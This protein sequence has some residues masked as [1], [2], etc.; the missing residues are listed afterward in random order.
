L[1]INRLEPGPSG[2]LG[3][4]ALTTEV[5]GPGVFRCWFRGGMATLRSVS[6]DTGIMT[7]HA[8]SDV[9]KEFSS[10]VPEGRFRFILTGSYQSWID[11]VS[12]TPLAPIGLSAAL[13]D[14]TGIPLSQ[15]TG[16][17]PGAGAWADFSFDGEDSVLL[18]PGLP[19]AL[20][21]R[22]PAGATIALRARSMG[23]DAILVVGAAE[24][25]FD[26]RASLWTEVRFTVAG[27]SDTDGVVIRGSSLGASILLD[28][29]RIDAPPPTPYEKWAETT[30]LLGHPLGAP[31]QDADNDGM[32][33]LV[34]FAFGLPPRADFQYGIVHPLAVSLVPRPGQADGLLVEFRTVPGVVYTIETQLPQNPTV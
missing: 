3:E 6:D 33:N 28:Q 10:P 11:Q 2:T 22:A 17:V 12:W 4:Y 21:V 23:S 20:T 26:L 9:W 5:T 29:L 18:L 30:G 32:V 34:E 14:G 24:K 7:V 13:D 15:V 25:R 16:A 31:S 27:F 19:H 8:N 1:E